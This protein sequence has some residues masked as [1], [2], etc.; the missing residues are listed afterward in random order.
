[1]ALR[2]AGFTVQP[3]HMVGSGCPDLIVGGS[4]VNVL[5]EL[6]D[7][8]KPPSARKLTPDEAEWHRDWKG[9]VCTVCS[10]LEA[11]EACQQLMGG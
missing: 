2:D 11:L 1:M 5:L 3:L 9:Q 8:S 10:A 6:K 7:G 4:G